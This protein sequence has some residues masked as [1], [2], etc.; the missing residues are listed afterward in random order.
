VCPRVGATLPPP[1]CRHGEQQ[2]TCSNNCL[3]ATPVAS[4]SVHLLVH[5][6]DKHD[7]VLGHIFRFNTLGTTRQRK[8]QLVH[9]T[10]PFSSCADPIRKP[11]LI[12]QA[13]TLRRSW[14][15]QSRSSSSHNSSRKWMK[16]LFQLPMDQD[17]SVP[18]MMAR[19]PRYEVTDAAC[20]QGWYQLCNDWLLHMNYF[21]CSGA[22]RHVIDK[23]LVA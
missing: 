1:S 10:L 14:Q 13:M 4:P 20:W 15:R 12:L 19:M 5:A 6:Y 23:L 7:S 2:S 17:E 3:L 11:T 22:S 8:R 18:L 16:C 9:M 21:W